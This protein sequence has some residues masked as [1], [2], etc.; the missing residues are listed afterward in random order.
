MW[1]WFSELLERK[2]L[3]PLGTAGL[4]LWLPITGALFS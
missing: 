3:L 4:S 1:Y 2:D